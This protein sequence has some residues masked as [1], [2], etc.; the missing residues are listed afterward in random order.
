MAERKIDLAWMRIFVEAVRRGSFSA[1]AAELGL[2]QPAVSYQ[3]RR[4]E[5]QVGHTLLLRRRQGV[6]L[7]PQGRR[8]FEIVSR[9]V[10]EI[11][12]LMR[13]YHASVRRPVLRLRTD[14]AFSTFWLMPRMSSFRAHHPGIDIQIVATQRFDAE[15][16]EPADV[17]IAF[18]AQ[19]DF[20]AGA[21]NLLPENVVPVC[22]PDYLDRNPQLREPRS[23]AASR[24]IHLDAASPSPWFDWDTYLAQSGVS[25]PPGGHGDLRFNTYN[26]VVQA[27]I[28]HQGVAIGWIG[29]IDSLLRAG[30][31]VPVAAAAFAPDR[32]YFLVRP[33]LPESDGE[34]LVDWLLSQTGTMDGD[35]TMP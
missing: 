30:V 24:L 5:E 19:N 4:L 23:L 20:G 12:E 22:T 3:I 35:V 21:V 25:R 8:L 28:E 27:A 26:L 1:A 13:E 18:G 15:E 16:M 31:L 11:D 32:G 7:T 10:G 9:S 17:A 34:K 6:E 29:L 14:Y 33:R 2:T